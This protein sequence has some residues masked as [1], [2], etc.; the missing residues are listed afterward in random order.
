MKK[1]SDIIIGHV[2]V[3]DDNCKES[4]DLKALGEVLDAIT[5]D[6]CTTKEYI[7]TLAFVNSGR[8]IDTTVLF[9]EREWER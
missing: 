6:L 8:K 5:E 3:N 2:R 1:V 7:K 4:L 9:K